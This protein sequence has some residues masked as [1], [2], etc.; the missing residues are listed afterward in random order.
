MVVPEAPVWMSPPPPAA[1]RVVNPVIRRLLVSPLGSRMPPALA[2]LEYVGRRTGKQIAIPV[3]VHDVDGDG[4]VVFTEAPWRRNFEGG[5][6]LTLVRGNNRRQGRGVLVEDPE[7]VA[8][9]LVAAVAKVGP[10]GLAMKTAPGHQITREELLRLGR[11][12]V[13]VHLDR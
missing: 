3:G 9:A 8:D 1:L 10:R 4:S 6:S 7:A 2:V 13:R 5:R 12:M 11:T